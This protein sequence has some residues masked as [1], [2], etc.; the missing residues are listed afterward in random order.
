MVPSYPC[1]SPNTLP[2][3]SPM[4]PLP[5][6]MNS[7]GEALNNSVYTCFAC[8]DKFQDKKQY[9][10][11]IR[12]EHGRKRYCKHCSEPFKQHKA[13]QQHQ[14]RC[15]LNPENQPKPATTTRPATPPPLQAPI[16]C[17]TPLL[18]EDPMWSSTDPWRRQTDSAPPAVVLDISLGIDEADELFDLATEA[19]I[20][21]AEIQ[22][23]IQSASNARSSSEQPTET[24]DAPIAPLMN[25]NIG[26]Q[27]T[28]RDFPLYQEGDVVVREVEE[29]TYYPNGETYTV[30][31][32][33]HIPVWLWRDQWPGL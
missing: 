33:E 3:H 31:C 11:H 20:P 29:T 30:R 4:I 16:G 14:K 1:T 5:C 26:P 6:R 27:H 2:T 18:N 24:T 8:G 19:D 9:E 15:N 25:V 23:T 13:L 10:G 17:S 28:R 22:P 32:R 7:F 21:V 12:Q